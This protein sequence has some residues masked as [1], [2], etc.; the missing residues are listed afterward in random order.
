MFRKYLMLVLAVVA[1]AAVGTGIWIISPGATPETAGAPGSPAW[2]SDAPASGPATPVPDSPVPDSPVPDSAVPDS[3]VPEPATAAPEQPADA[4]PP[5]APEDQ[6][7]Q[8]ADNSAA[9]DAPVRVPSA[10][11]S[12]CTTLRSSLAEY[13]ETAKTVGPPGFRTL[14]MGLE[15]L[16]GAVDSMAS[17]NEQ[18]VSVLQE[19]GDVRRQW[20]T[21]LSALDD[22]MDAD[23]EMAAGEALIS[24]QT[25]RDSL[26]CTS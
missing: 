15:D 16:E 21:A 10:V 22:G 26:V 2:V 19:L 3:A 23:A 24:L 7:P 11:V 18:Y 17:S 1:A 14:L 20:S 8:P 4:A 25:A 9:P 5:A 6:R 12:D 13:Q